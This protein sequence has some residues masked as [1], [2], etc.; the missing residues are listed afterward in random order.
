VF[1]HRSVVW[2]RPRDHDPMFRL[3]SSKY[4][5]VKFGLW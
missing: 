4:P 3:T 1:V 2:L 5:P